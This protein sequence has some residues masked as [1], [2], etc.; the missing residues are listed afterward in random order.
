MAIITGTNGSEIC[1]GT[2]GADKMYGLGGDDDLR[3][4]DGDDILYGDG[5][6]A[7]HWLRRTCGCIRAPRSGSDGTLRQR[8]HRWRQGQRSALRRRTATTCCVAGWAT[9]GSTAATASTS[10][11]S[12]TPRPDFPQPDQRL[13]RVRRWHR[14]AV[15]DRER[16]RHELRSDTL[17]GNSGANGLQGNAGNDL[18]EGQGGADALFGMLGDDQVYGGA[19]DD[20]LID[21]L[22]TNILNGGDGI[23]TAISP[24]R[25]RRSRSTSPP[26][27]PPWVPART[28]WPGSSTS[29]AATGT[30]TCVATAAPIASRA[31]TA[32]TSW[33]AAAAATC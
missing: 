32:T 31:T 7:D 8:H 10:P 19:G 29:L 1:P 14:S 26:A 33:T 27:A 30:T 5:K 22:G 20:V 25:P 9:T 16:P 24:P 12:T 11:R 3:G 18:I 2:S 17:T 13:L 28:R 4:L 6:A 23:D 15:R 21:D